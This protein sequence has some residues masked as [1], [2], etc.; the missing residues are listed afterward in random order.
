MSTNE[1]SPSEVDGARDEE[2]MASAVE[3]NPEP[4]TPLLAAA[5]VE[6]LELLVDEPVVIR[7]E[8][9]LE[10]PRAAPRLEAGELLAVEPEVSE[11]EDVLVAVFEETIAVVE[12]MIEDEPAL[13]L[14]AFELELREET[15]LPL[16]LLRLPCNCWASSAAKRSAWIEP[17][18]RTV[19]FS[20][21][22]EMTAVRKAA[23]AGPPPLSGSLR[24]T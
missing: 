9:R 4:I 5:E 3:P 15:R 1:K 19:R 13:I 7:S 8:N 14:E 10:E 17:H 20:S 2:G 11:E 12:A 22:D 6:A 21:P 23:P 16:E 18:S 24:F